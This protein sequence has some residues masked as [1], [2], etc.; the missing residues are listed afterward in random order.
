M[1]ADDPRDR[2]GLDPLMR[3]F[4]RRPWALGAIILLAVVALYAA[5][6]LIGPPGG[7]H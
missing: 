2:T 1:L 5:L 3:W 4:L 6:L 7:R